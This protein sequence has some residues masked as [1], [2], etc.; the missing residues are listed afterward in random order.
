MNRMHVLGLSEKCTAKLNGWLLIILMSL[1]SAN[2]HLQYPCLL[3]I[4]ETLGATDFIMQ[5]SLILSP[6][7]AIFS[8]I[9]VGCY[10]TKYKAK[11]LLISCTL[12]F[13]MGTLTCGLAENQLAFFVGRSLQV[14]GDSGISII[15]FALLAALLSP[16]VLAY[17]LGYS[18]ILTAATTIFSPLLGA[19]LLLRWGWRTPFLFLTIICLPLY[20]Y[21]YLSYC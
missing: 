12:S 3:A 11:S 10:S 2:M 9:F 17:Y 13:I 14:L 4:K 1:L 7:L 16:K 21:L 18:S 6:G 15:G 19:A 5:A 20:A 8:N